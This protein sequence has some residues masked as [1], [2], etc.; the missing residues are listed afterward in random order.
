V[1]HERTDQACDT[2]RGFRERPAQ[3]V[4]EK[5]VPADSMPAGARWFTAHQPFTPVVEC[6][7]ALLTGAPVGDTAQPAPA[8]CAAIAL[9][10]YLWARAAFRRGTRVTR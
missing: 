3:G 1:W 10:G 6:L 5:F 9:A 8:W 4:R 7:R 2:R